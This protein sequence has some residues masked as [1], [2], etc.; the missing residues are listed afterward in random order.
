[1]R[2]SAPSLSS[3]REHAA[4]RLLR[5]RGQ[6]TARQLRQRS[7]QRAGDDRL[8]RRSA[9][10]HDPLR[11]RPHRRRASSPSRPTATSSS[12]PPR[13]SRCCSTPTATASPTPGSAP[14]FAAVPVRQSRPRGHAD[15]RLR[16][17]ADERLPLG[18]RVRRPHRHGHDGDRRERHSGRRPRG[19]HARDRRAAPPL[20]ERRQRRQRRR[21]GRRDHA[22]GPARAH[23]ALRSRRGSRRAATRPARARLFAY[24]LRN[25]T[26]L[27]IDS[28]GRLWGAEN[29]RDNLMVGGDIHFDNPA[30]EVNLFDTARPGR[31]YGYPFCWSEGI[32]MDTAMAKGRWDAAP[33]SRSTGRLHGGDVPGQER[34]RPARVRRSA[35]TS[36]RSTSSSTA[37]AA[38]RR[39]CRATCS[40]PRTARG[41]ANRSRSAA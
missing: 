26:A 38:T 16:V 27:S 21:P 10:L 15:A 34:R 35:R 2:H 19:A 9:L 18:L 4:R 22:P 17:V 40:S 39:R 32:W 8:H 36:R 30:E 14:T 3:F 12:P 20:R 24:G 28:K 41:T 29:G 5:R 11:G 7:R 6:A 13:R 25:E 31:N 37:A 1:M 33:G 23:P